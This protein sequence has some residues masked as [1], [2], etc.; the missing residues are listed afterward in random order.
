MLRKYTKKELGDKMK[1]I[2]YDMAGGEGGVECWLD[3]Y[4][5]EYKEMYNRK[6]TNKELLGYIIK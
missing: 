1:F 3:L 2:F 6:P 5:K 4:R